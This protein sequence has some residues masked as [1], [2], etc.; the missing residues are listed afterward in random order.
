MQR[1]SKIYFT[2][3]TVKVDLEVMTL[4]GIHVYK[5]DRNCV[6]K[7]F[8]PWSEENTPLENF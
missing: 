1:T 6:E 3:D 7:V 5:K 4:T 8:F 2:D